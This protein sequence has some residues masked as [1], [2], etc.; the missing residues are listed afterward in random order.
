MHCFGDQFFARAAFAED[1]Y[2]NSATCRAAHNVGDF[3]QLRRGTDQPGQSFC[4]GR[5]CGFCGGAAF[6]KG[7][8]NFEELG[9]MLVFCFALLMLINKIPGLLSGVVTGASV[10]GAGIGQFGAG[11]AVGAAGMAAAAAATG[12]AM[13]AASAANAAGGAHALTAAFA[14]AGENVQSGADVLT[15]MWTGGGGESKREESTGNTPYAQAAGFA[16]SGAA[17]AFGG[18]SAVKAEGQG[19]NASGKHKA[20]LDQARGKTGESRDSAGSGSTRR[21]QGGQKQSSGGLM[22]SVG[23]AGLIAADT[24]AN[25]AKGTAQLAMEKMASLKEAAGDRIA[26]TPGG[27]IAAAFKTANANDE[28]GAIVGS[29]PTFGGNNLA[30]AGTSD[31]DAAAEVAA[32]ANRDT[33][34]T[35]ARTT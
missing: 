19:G 25:L 24:A 13:L 33:G 12:G 32:F 7:T 8:L 4:A 10:G 18:N 15:S 20:T 22:S 21:A 27:K 17:Q 34:S 6:L 28:A 11:M 31:A 23:N 30:G 1:Q 16:P 26:E 9:V 3:Q 14:K 29:T 2:R 35:W 5:R